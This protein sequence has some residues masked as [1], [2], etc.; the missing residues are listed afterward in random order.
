M[1]GTATVRSRA[2][3]ELCTSSRRSAGVEVT[4]GSGLTFGVRRSEPARRTEPRSLHFDEGRVPP[5]TGLVEAYSRG[6]DN[7]SWD[8]AQFVGGGDDASDLLTP[9]QRAEAT[10]RAKD[11]MD[12]ERFR[13]RLNLSAA[14]G[15]GTSKKA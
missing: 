1:N 7:P 13:K 6:I 14:E 11:M 5:N 2:S 9:E 4:I 12:T 8:V 3:T 10:Q 15:E